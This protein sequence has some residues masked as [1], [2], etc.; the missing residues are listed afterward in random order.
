MSPARNHTPQR[1]RLLIVDDHPMMREGLTNL[2]GNQPD[3]EVCGEADN[4]AQAL[5]MIPATMPDLVLAD[6][7]LPGRSGLELVKDIASMHPQV[8]TLVVSMH[9]ESVYAER[10]LRAGGRGYVMKKEGGKRILAAIRSVL[11]GEIAVSEKMSAKILQIFSGRRDGA[12]HSPVELLTDREFEVF[13]LIGRGCSTREMAGTL[14]LSAKT[15][16]VHR[17]HIKEKLQIKTAAE[18]ISYAARWAASSPA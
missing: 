5:E 14:H 18:L 15:V 9:E 2:I 11:A 17:A 12:P 10:V 13:Q 3:L 7:T 8:M 16:E 1:K 6:I 4:A